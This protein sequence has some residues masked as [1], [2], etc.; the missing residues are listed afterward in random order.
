[1][2]GFV[3]KVIG[4]AVDVALPAG[5]LP[6]LFTALTVTNPQIDAKQDNLVLE[7]AQ[8]IGESMVRAIPTDPPPAG[9][10][11]GYQ[12]KSTGAPDAVPAGP[13]A[14]PR[15]LQPGRQLDSLEPTGESD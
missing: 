1:V 15:L 4:A 5:G 8:Y 2:T 12:L 9:L 7:V 10:V 3:N 11:C 13:E 14:L 6:P